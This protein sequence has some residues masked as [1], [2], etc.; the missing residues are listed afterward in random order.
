MTQE[1]DS[2]G[3][4]NLTLRI[5]GT[6]S[7]GMHDIA[8]SFM[9]LPALE[10]L[11]LGIRTEDNGRKDLLRVHGQRVEGRNILQAVLEAAR[12]KDPQIPPIMVDI[13]KK[14]PPGSG[15]GAG[16]G[17][18]AA[19]ASW[20]SR[21]M[22]IEFTVEELLEIGSDV[23]FLFHGSDLS[24]MAGAGE[25][26]LRRITG[27]AG[28]FKTVVAVPGWSCSTPVMYRRADGFYRKEGWKYSEGEAYE[29]ALVILGSLEKR[30]TVG[31]LP[32]DFV[33]LLLASH[34]GYRLLFEAAENGGALAWG[35]SG[36][37]S[38]FF[39]LFNSEN[40]DVPPLGLFEEAGF[41]RK[42]LLL[43]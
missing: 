7:D 40:V 33:P 38:S 36:S 41:V 25:K 13:W 18:A 24:F 43:G 19:L 35:I 20:L 26:P 4:L 17:N 37:G 30:Q 23:P 11:T 5:T 10:K 2:P 39:C 1:I 15:L 8:S 27:V 34:P 16:S 6:R 21:E 32:N 9:R 28:L 3:K 12:K 31:L 14:V 29:E 42:I 22:G